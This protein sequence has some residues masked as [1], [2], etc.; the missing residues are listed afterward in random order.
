MLQEIIQIKNILNEVGFS[1]KE[2]QIYLALVEAGNPLP[3]SRI[4]RVTHIS[5]QNCYALLE[6][7]IKKGA[8][9]TALDGNIRRFSAGSPD[10]IAFALEHKRKDLDA[11]KQKVQSLKP[12]LNKLSPKQISLPEVKYFEGEAGIKALYSEVVSHKDDT[13]RALSTAELAEYL[14]SAYIQD[15]IVKNRVKNNLYSKILIAP[16]FPKK[17]HN[18]SKKLKRE[19]R[20]A[21][22]TKASA[23]VVIIKDSVYF[24]SFKSNPFGLVVRSKYIVEVLTAVFDEVWRNAKKT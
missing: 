2:Q 12:L 10:N 11:Q 6:N 14:G 22:F 13:I 18:T 1:S 17:F 20:L 16:G 21:P 15:V 8:V 5:R 7:L 9:Y 19:S 24:I 4:A 23:N 3:A